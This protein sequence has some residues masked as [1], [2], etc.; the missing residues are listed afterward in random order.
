[1]ISGHSWSNYI[2]CDLI[3]RWLNPVSHIMKPRFKACWVHSSG[4]LSDETVQKWKF[5]CFQSFSWETTSL[6]IL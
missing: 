3:A 2:I 5:L 4:V 1:M 6:H